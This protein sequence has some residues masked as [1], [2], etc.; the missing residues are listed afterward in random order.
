MESTGLTR[1][2]RCGGTDL[3]DREVE[4]LLSMDKYVVRCRVTATVCHQCGERYFDPETV[5]GFEEMRARVRTGD[6]TG[7]RPA[8]EILE[9]AA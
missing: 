6:L 1:C 3:V 7:F 5:R 2:F 9:P 8:G 4:E